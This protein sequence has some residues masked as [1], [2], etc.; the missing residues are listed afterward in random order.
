MENYGNNDIGKYPD[1]PLNGSNGISIFL[2]IPNRVFKVF[3]RR[4]NTNTDLRV[5]FPNKDTLRLFDN[6]NNGNGRLRI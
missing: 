6:E 1:A 4:N 5:Y 2:S 3:D